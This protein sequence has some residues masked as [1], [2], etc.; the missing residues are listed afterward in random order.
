MWQ[1]LKIKN[2]KEICAFW[3]TGSLQVDRVEKQS[4]KW[5]VTN[6]IFKVYSKDKL[7]NQRLSWMEVWNTLQVIVMAWGIC[8]VSLSAIQVPLPDLQELVIPWSDKGAI[9]GYP[10]PKSRGTLAGRELNFNYCFCHGFPK[11]SRA[12]PGGKLGL[13]GAHSMGS[14]CF[15]EPLLPAL[16]GCPSLPQVLSHSAKPFLAVPGT[17]HGLLTSYSTSHT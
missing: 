8:F 4:L 6:M 14:T 3:E 12:V 15:P 13:S 16:P 17:D 10:I 2:E 1:K 9:R 7:A 5:Q 11:S